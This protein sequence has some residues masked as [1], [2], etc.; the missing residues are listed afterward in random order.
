MA[1]LKMVYSKWFAQKNYYLFLEL[2]SLQEYLESIQ[3]NYF[4]PEIEVVV[5]S[6]GKNKLSSKQF[7][8]LK[9]YVDEN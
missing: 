3:D 5:N 2:V 6:S 9:E 1:D 7:T 8:L 4:Y